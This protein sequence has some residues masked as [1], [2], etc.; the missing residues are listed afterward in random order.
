LDSF[1]K[2]SK[3]FTNFSLEI[4]IK[5]ILVKKKECKSCCWFR[6]CCCCCCCVHTLDPRSPGAPGAPGVPA[7][8]CQ[9]Q[10]VKTHINF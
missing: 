8:P 7:N 4:L 5:H 10:A 9:D 2:Y 3:N 6:Y 1:L